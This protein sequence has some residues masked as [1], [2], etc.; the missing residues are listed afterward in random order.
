MNKKAKI[1]VLHMKELIYTGL[2]VLLVLLFVLVFLLMF[3]PGEDSGSARSLY[4][5]GQYTTSLTFQ[6]NVVDVVV[7]VDDHSITSISL[8]NLEEAVS[9]MYPLLEPTLEELSAE[10][11]SKQSLDNIQLSENNKYT[12]MVLLDAIASSLEQAGN[13][14]SSDNISG[15][16]LP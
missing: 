5:P 6:G 10:I 13:I 7:T 16:S 3:S 8:N 1:I 4:T 9:V 12:S 11:L 14:S 2:I 15:N